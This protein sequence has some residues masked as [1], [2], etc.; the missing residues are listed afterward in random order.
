M[1]ENI[2]TSF[3]EKFNRINNLKW[4]PWVGKNYCKKKN[5]R[6]LVVGESHY[7]KN[8]KDVEDAKYWDFTR[9]F[10]FNHTISN[11]YATMEILRNTERALFY[12]EP[13]DKQIISF[14]KSIAFF[15]IVQRILSGRQDRPDESDFSTG[16][17]TFFKV[18]DIIR[19]DYCLFCG[20][21]ASN[22][23]FHFMKALEDNNYKS[24]GIMW[25]NRIGN[26]YSRIANI[27]TKDGY[28]C[29]LVFMKHPS[30]YFPWESWGDFIYEQMSDY[31]NALT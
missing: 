15:N 13:T 29:N 10:V 18:L 1:L 19:P 20:V 31:T 24:E 22:Y 7:A 16:W 26:T 30:S 2:N 27:E 3:D 28:N 6:L 17:D 25:L 14:W 5:K 4:L 21:E 12:G 23:S 9:W 11:P 8:K